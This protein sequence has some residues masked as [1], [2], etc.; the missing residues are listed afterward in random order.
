MNY[1]LHH[2]LWTHIP[3]LALFV[4]LVIYI[5]LSSPFP[6]EAP[7][8]FSITGYPDSYGSP[9]VSIGIGLALSVLYIVLSVFLDELW[10]RQENRKTFNWLSLFDE[11]TVGLLAGFT[12]G[13]I[14]F[15]PSNSATFDIPWNLL[16]LTTCTA[17]AAA[18][19]LEVIRPYRPYSEHFREDDTGKLKNMVAERIKSGQPLVY[20]ELQNPAYIT[21][22]VILLPAIMFISALFTWT[23]QTWLSV[24]LIIVGLAFF[25]FYGG[26]RVLVTGEK[27][28]VKLGIFGI[29]LLRLNTSDIAA[30]ELHT[31]S[32]LHDFGGYGIRFNSE[33]KAY[34]M[35]GNRGV[36]ITTT[37]AKKYLL[38]SDKPDHLAVVIQAVARTPK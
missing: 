10:A 16:L 33:M 13:Y 4:I 22:L 35:R 11:V 24:L 20:W 36:K 19:V 9:W 1:R 5:L 12:I 26:M 8:H 34:F 7:L 25:L 38:G 31:F 23:S 29:R 2:P 27:V 3:A 21:I 37:Q 18:V 15:F 17:T 14:Q 30:V 28:L 32:P 6:A